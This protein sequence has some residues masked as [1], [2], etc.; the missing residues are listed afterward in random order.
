M[1]KPP[2]LKKPK[3]K[4]PA[5]TIEERNLFLDSIGGTKPLGARDRL[6]VPPPPPAAVRVVPP[7]VA[8]K[9]TVEGDSARYSARAPG[10][11]LAQVAQLRRAHAEDTLDLHGDT[12]QAGIERRNGQ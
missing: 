10:V 4:P 1:A 3:P 2:K 12:T 8:V 6:P 11:S 7:P 9:L 5:V